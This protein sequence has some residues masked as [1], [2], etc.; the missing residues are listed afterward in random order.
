[1]RA[2]STCSVGQFD[3]G[4]EIGD[5]LAGD[6]AL[7]AAGIAM[8]HDDFGARLEALDGA[9]VHLIG[10]ERI[11]EPGIP[12]APAPGAAIA[13]IRPPVAIGARPERIAI[14]P[15]LDIA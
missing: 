9:H 10:P 14:D 12:P 7:V 2:L 3:G 5:H 4:A 1:M 8:R 13:P 6:E 11:A 15:R